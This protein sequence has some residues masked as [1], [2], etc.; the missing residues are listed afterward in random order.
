MPHAQSGIPHI[1]CATGIFTTESLL[2]RHS[3]S[4][5]PEAAA[6]TTGTEDT[7]HTV[8]NPCHVRPQS[9]PS[10]PPPWP[11]F[12]TPFRPPLPFLVVPPSNLLRVPYFRLSLLRRL[13]ANLPSPSGL[14]SAPA[15]GGVHHS[16]SQH[17][18]SDPDS[19]AIPAQVRSAI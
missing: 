12:P 11:P 19:I 3:I 7:T 2:L 13:H 18:S 4:H 15:P 17:E 6:H 10:R 5:L 1:P 14:S 9:P 16:S 8:T